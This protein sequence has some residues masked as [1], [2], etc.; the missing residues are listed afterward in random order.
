MI[1]AAILLIF[2]TVLLILGAPF[3]LFCLISKISA[4]LFVIAKWVMR[5]SRALRAMDENPLAIMYCNLAVA[6]L[7]YIT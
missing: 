4:P 7:S 2:Y 5:V 6:K 1:R 3:V